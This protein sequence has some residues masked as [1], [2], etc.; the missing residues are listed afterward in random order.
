VR[1]EWVGVKGGRR[2]TRGVEEWRGE[3][4]RRRGGEGEER[5]RVA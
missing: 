4:V 3:R 1:G 2:G 5:R